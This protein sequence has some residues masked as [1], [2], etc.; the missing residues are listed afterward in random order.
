MKTIELPKI[1]GSGVNH[2]LGKEYEITYDLGRIVTQK[3]TRI[4][5]LEAELLALKQKHGL[6]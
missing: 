4:K 3:K 1:S 6:I 2:P 5:E